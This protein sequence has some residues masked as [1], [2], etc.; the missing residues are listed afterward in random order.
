M[1]RAGTGS[2]E[3]GLRRLRLCE[4]QRQAGWLDAPAAPD[5]VERR[6]GIEAGPG[7]RGDGAAIQC[8]PRGKPRHEGMAAAHRD[9]AHDGIDAA[10]LREGPRRHQAGPAAPGVA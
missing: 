3:I 6:H 4:Q 8:V 5:H 9:E 1:S 2:S 10:D 7:D